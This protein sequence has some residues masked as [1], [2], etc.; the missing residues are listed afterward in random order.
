MDVRQA[1]LDRT[2]EAAGGVAGRL[3]DRGAGAAPQVTSS[4]IRAMTA[5]RRERQELFP[6]ALGTDSCWEVLLQLY[7]AHLDQHRLNIGRLT[8][9]SGLPATTV[10]RAL[11]TLAAADLSARSKDPLDRRAVMVKLTDQGIARM[12]LFFAR[13]GTRAVLL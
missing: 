13:S 10:L 6:G 1:A 7:R 11:E 5:V 4:L 3:E 12:T 8:M 9:R 2:L